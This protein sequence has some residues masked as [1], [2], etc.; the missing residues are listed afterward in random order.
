MYS[1]AVEF[2][3]RATK[4]ADLETSDS[5]VEVFQGSKRIKITSSFAQAKK[6]VAHKSATEPPKVAALPKKSPEAK[7]AQK[8]TPSQ[9]RPLS[10]VRLNQRSSIEPLKEIENVPMRESLELS[11][12]DNPW[13]VIEQGAQMGKFILQWT[14]TYMAAGIF[15][16]KNTS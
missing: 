9:F 16:C 10:L 6:S 14:F 7:L 13:L 15:H 3:K 4:T 12:S 1:K 2:A 11:N 5:E 8:S